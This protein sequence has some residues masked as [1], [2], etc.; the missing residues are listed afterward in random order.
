MLPK[1]HLMSHSRISYSRWV[2]TPSWLSELWRSFLYRSSVYSEA[3]LVF[4]TV[5]RLPAMQETQV[6]FLG[7]EN[8]LEKVMAIHSSPLAW[9]ISWTEEPD[10]LQSMGS[11]RVRHDWATSLHFTSLHNIW[12]SPESGLSSSSCYWEEGQAVFHKVS[13]SFSAQS[14]P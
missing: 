12:N 9:K 4:Q 5:K 6:R 2:I 7:W 14:N 11:Q 13:L 10:K 3:S 1:A 8:P